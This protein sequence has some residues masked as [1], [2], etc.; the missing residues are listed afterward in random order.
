MAELDRHACR[1]HVENCFN[2]QKMVDSYEEV[3]WQIL[4]E[5]MT[6]NK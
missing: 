6:Q 4:A 5:R 3:Y 1:Q 2:V